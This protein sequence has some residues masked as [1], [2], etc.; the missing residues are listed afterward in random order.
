VIEV[1]SDPALDKRIKRD[2]YARFGVPEY[3]VV[4]PALDQ[5]DVYRYAEAGYG[6]PEILEPGDTL[7]TAL[8]PGLAIDLAELFRR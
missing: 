1:V 3:W 5:V 4:D 6:K 8:I 2:L 7:T